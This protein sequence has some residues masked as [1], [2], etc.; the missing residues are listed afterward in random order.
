LAAN[1]RLGLQNVSHPGSIGQY[2]KLPRNR[3][4]F[5]GCVSFC[6][7]PFLKET[8]TE[9]ETISFAEGFSIVAIVLIISIKYM[10]TAHH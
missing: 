1:H 2:E 6:L 10:E 4:L 8:S 5:G 9:R 7:F 3:K